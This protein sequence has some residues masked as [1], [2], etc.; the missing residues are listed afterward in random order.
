MG[1]FYILYLL[2]SISSEYPFTKQ[3]LRHMG[4]TWKNIRQ[5]VKTIVQILQK[6]FIWN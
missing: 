5:N 2:F 3:T 6:H 4:N 1:N